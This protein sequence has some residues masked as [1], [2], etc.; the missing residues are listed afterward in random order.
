M[1]FASILLVILLLGGCATGPTLYSEAAPVS[2]SNI[3][4]GYQK[5]SQPKEGFI[6]VIIVRD[7]GMLG[8]ASPAKLSIDGE[9]V[10]KFWSGERLE[11]FLPPDTY[12]FALE[13][14]PR[15]LGSVAEHEVVIKAGKP[16]AFRI[17]LDL[18]GTFSLQRSTLLE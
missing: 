11:L 10:A 15:L 7:T 3:L 1:K 6:R 17:A 13:P 9:A 8:A 12:V 5:F 14:S 18:K 2:A 4:D 16:T